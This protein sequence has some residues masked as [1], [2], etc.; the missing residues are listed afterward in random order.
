[1]EY[2][3][4]FAASE[5]SK[6]EYELTRERGLWGPDKPSLL[7]KWMVDIVEGKGVWLRVWFR[8][9][10]ASWPD[11]LSLPDTW[12]VDIVEGKRVWFRVWGPDKPS[13]DGGHCRG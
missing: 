11:K 12:M 8:V 5:W 9:V 3:L 6:I 7:D 2:R 4:R 1:M 10:G 13:L